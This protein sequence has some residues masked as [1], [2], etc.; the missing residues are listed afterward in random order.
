MIGVVLATGPAWAQ[1]Q[2]IVPPD[3]HRVE[4][5]NGVSDTGVIGAT[6][7]RIDPYGWGAFVYDAGDWVDLHPGSSASRTLGVSA[8]GRTV[9][10]VMTWPG[11][12]LFV[13]G[14]FGDATLPA[15]PGGVLGAAAL[16]L[17][18]SSVLTVVRPPDPSGPYE[19]RRWRDGSTQTV[20][21][22]PARY[23][24]HANLLAGADGGVFTIS[25]DI[26][27]FDPYAS[28]RRV[29][30]A[31]ADGLVELPTLG[32]AA[33]IQSS[34]TAMDATGSVI[35]GIESAWD[36]PDP[37]RLDWRTWVWRDGAMSEL[38]VPGF[39]RLTVGS[40]SAD[41]SLMLASGVTTDGFGYETP[42]S[43]LIHADGRTESVTDLLADTGI[44]LGLGERAWAE[45]MS[46]DGGWIAGT[47]V[48][49]DGFGAP[50]ETV[51]TLRVPT[52]G[53]LAPV[54]F[55]GLLAARRRR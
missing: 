17:D 33:Y 27:Y 29:V 53:V 40:I 13:R 6:L 21:T 31:D 51:F 9:L 48:R 43:L 11:S 34:A 8:D 52:P 10:S 44:T 47:I 12:G 3:T 30:R 19:I 45:R 4:R 15:P 20:L 37:S 26:G 22:M 32:H 14:P 25:A 28:P 5:I 39:D 18:G 49:L 23:T 46:P 55:A 35:A 2:E 42:G 50:S 36:G 24:D 38:A 54:A 41:G 16:S 1:V 7:T